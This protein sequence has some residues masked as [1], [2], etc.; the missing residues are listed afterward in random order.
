MLQLSACTC[1]FEELVLPLRADLIN[2][3]RRLTGSDKAKAD[4]IVHDVIVKALKAWH[5]FKPITDPHQET[6]TWLYRLVSN[7]FCKDYRHHKLRRRH[8]EERPDEVFEITHGQP[9]EAGPVIGMSDEVM[10]AMT[11]LLPEHQDILHRHYVLGQNYKEIAEATGIPIGTVNSRLARARSRLGPMIAQYAKT[12]YGLEAL[13]GKPKPKKRLARGSVPE[14]A[15]RDAF[16]TSFPVVD[17]AFAE[18]AEVEEPDTYA[19]DRIVAGY[20]GF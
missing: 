10:R 17:A 16:P 4:D 6:R 3:A 18:A 15:F 7:Q 9:E 13:P 20:D 12:N 14:I 5:R 11:R 8:I 2:F 1:T 19:I